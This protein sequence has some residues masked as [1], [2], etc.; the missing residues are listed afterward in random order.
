MQH[1]VKN[2][3]LKQT[4]CFPYKKVDYQNIDHVLWLKNVAIDS[5]STGI[6]FLHPKGKVTYAN[7]AA[8]KIWGWSREQFLGSYPTVAAQSPDCLVEI[9]RIVHDEGSWCGEISTIRKGGTSKVVYLQA[10]LIKNTEG[11]PVC[12]MVSFVDITE[13]K[14][15]EKQMLIKDKA[16][17]KSINGIVITDIEGNISYVNDAFYKMWGGVY[18]EEVIGHQVF[19]FSNA[20]DVGKEIYKTALEKGKWFGEVIANRRDGSTYDAQCSMHTVTDPETDTTHAVYSFIDITDRKAAERELKKYHVQLEM[21]VIERT[22]ELESLNRANI[23]EIEERKRAEKLLLQKEKDLI[24]KSQELVELNSALKVLLKQRE[25]DKEDVAKDV[26]SNIE[27]NIL[28]YL[29]K[30]QSSSTINH[31]DKEYIEVIALEINNLVSPFLRNLSNQYSKFTPTEIKV[32]NLIKDGKATK[33]ISELLNISP[34]SVEFHRKHIREKL[35]IVNKK[36][37]LRSY[38]I[39]LT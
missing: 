16:I 39:S 20:G 3:G 32:S 21:R 22:K 1:D 27:K 4:R 28:P 38:L 8:L 9:F 17:E 34:L 7:D 11:D 10:T 36:V 14:N 18:P 33:E 6:I 26:F 25:Q 31:R 2:K 12:A 15:L 19:D 23:R 13:K 37:N 24:E 5:S 35:D 30:L 29:K